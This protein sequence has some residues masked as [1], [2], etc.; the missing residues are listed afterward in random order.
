MHASKFL[1]V[2]I[3]AL[4]HI[5]G[6]NFSPVKQDTSQTSTPVETAKSQTSETDSHESSALGHRG[7]ENDLKYSEFERAASGN[8]AKKTP[9]LTS[10]ADLWREIADNLEFPRHINQNRVKQKV[11]W[12]AR[13]QAYL[14]RVADRANPYLFHIVS[15]LKRRNMPLDLAL[16]PIVE[17]AYQPFALSPSRAAGLWQFIPATGKRYGLK[18]NWWYDGR[19][20]VV[21]ATDSALKY[22]SDLNKR[23]NGNWFHAI[24]AYN[25]G[26]GNI[27]K[28]IERNRRSGKATDFWSLRLHRE[29]QQYLPN[30]L[31]IAEI[32][33]NPA[34]YNVKLKPIANQAHFKMVDTGGQIDLATVSELSNLDMDRI[35][36]L[37]PAFNRWATAPDGPH[38]ILL[39]IRI[40]DT[41]G[42]KLKSLP[43]EERIRWQQHVIKRGDT[44]GGIAQRYG[45]SVTA[46]KQ[47]NGLKK[48]SNSRRSFTSN[49][50]CQ[51]TSG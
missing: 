48:P 9:A 27:E 28:S 32:V 11:E 46:L 6:C 41:V 7:T 8:K 40:A 31:A 19:R 4:L 12:F 20:D 21:A 49:T 33:S 26:E 37:N 5:S 38:R 45:S 22:L 43:K 51:A 13:N 15:E 30:L 16:L 36:K 3:I 34:K 39:P 14:D 17:S 42:N 29:T 24:A 2:L 25:T 1:P 23:F 47:A 18:Q 35:Y 10:N 44:L 50:C